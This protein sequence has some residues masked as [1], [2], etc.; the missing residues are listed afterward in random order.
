MLRL[1]VL[2]GLLVWPAL[3]A[4]QPAADK[5]LEA[6]RLGGEAL[7]AFQRGDWRAAYDGFSSAE[8]LTH[9]P[10][11]VLYMARA[12]RNENALVEARELYGR[13]AAE[14]LYATAPQPWRT[15]VADAAA[16]FGEVSRRIPSVSIR[17]RALESGESV[18]IDGK[19]VQAGR[20]AGEIELNPGE[21]TIAIQRAEGPLSERTVTLEEGARGVV[22]TL[23]SEPPRIAPPAVRPR[24]ESSQVEPRQDAARSER[25]SNRYATLATITGIVGLAGVAVGS[26]AG[27]V[28]IGKSQDAKEGCEDNVCP[29]A[30]ERQA[31]IAGDYATLS[32]IGF[33]V[34]GVGLGASATLFW[35]MPSISARGEFSG[36]AVGAAY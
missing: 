13:V 26:V 35:V 4:A 9:S 28:A 6:V 36:I 16:E 23:D 24:V 11:F 1:M 7:G 18:L 10:V 31:D 15:A 32:T 30:N 8:A 14:H 5:N 33:V 17:V 34:G 12:R 27:I 25:S 29:E 3:A 19:P 20:L 21:H 22:V 2:V